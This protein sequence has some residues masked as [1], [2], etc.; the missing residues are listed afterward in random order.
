[1]DRRH[2]HGP[3]WDWD[4]AERVGKLIVSAAAAVAQLL[5]AIHQVH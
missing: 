5:D 3:W 1:M 4:K 2:R